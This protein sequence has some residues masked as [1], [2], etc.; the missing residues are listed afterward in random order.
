MVAAIGAG[1][2]RRLAAD[3]DEAR[4]IAVE[5]GSRAA[6]EAA[7]SEEH[8][9]LHDSALQTLEAIAAGHKL[10]AEE[11]RHHASREAASLRRAL[12]GERA[13][14]GGLTRALEDLA[15]QMS[16]RGLSI[17]LLTGELEVEPED[18]VSAA[19]R[20]AS[21][22]ALMNVAK[23]AGVSRAVVRAASNS[24][25]GVIVTIRDRGRGFD[26]ASA[27]R[28]FGLDH[29][30]I[31]RLGELGGRVELWSEPGKGTKIE[32]RVPI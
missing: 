25:D 23:H 13:A 10:D 27:H 24:V 12:S 2:V 29:S 16:D 30:I 26:P 11:V 28:G 32:M 3:L 18:H 22:E 14:V 8:R 20:E 6:A 21:R 4:H 19:L 17:E 9:M 31:G 1:L 15:V 7:R 5:E